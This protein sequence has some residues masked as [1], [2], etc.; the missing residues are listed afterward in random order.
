MLQN[1][2]YRAEL[3]SDKDGPYIMSGSDGVTFYVN[4]YDCDKNTPPSC[5]TLYFVTNSFDAT[6]TATPEALLKWDADQGWVTA[7]LDSK[8]KPY[9]RMYVSTTGGVTGAYLEEM[10]RI[11]TG[12]LAKFTKFLN[13]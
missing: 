13:L 12:K 2:G 5:E 6:P 8:N 11:W 3:G 10:V 9:L 1:G 7:L 4:F